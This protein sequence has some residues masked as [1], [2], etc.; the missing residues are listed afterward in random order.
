MS[1]KIA[2]GKYKGLRLDTPSS[3]ITRPTAEVLRQAV[4]NICQHRI[5]GAF[6]LDLFAGSGA[7]GIEALSQGASH[8]TFIEKD[9]NALHCLKKNLQKIEEDGALVY[10]SDVLVALK[11]LPKNYFDLVYIDPPYGDEK[12]MLFA[13]RFLD[14]IF[15]NIGSILK[16]G[17]LIFLEFSAY[18]KKDF[19]QITTPGMSWKN[20]RVYGRSKLHIFE[21]TS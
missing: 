21:Y 16:N 15:E 13:E 11:K 6:F 7:M 2:G 18:S 10:G 14:K 3:H 17:A 19:S 1:L 8:A 9:R 20:S 12:E 4:F 5:E